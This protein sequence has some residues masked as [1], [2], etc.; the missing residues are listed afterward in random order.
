MRS[1]F[2]AKFFFCLS[3]L[4]VV[5]WFASCGQQAQVPFFSPSS[6]AE[7][8]SVLLPLSGDARK[9]RIQGGGSALFAFPAAENGGTALASGALE[10]SLEI[11]GAGSGESA[12][13]P[14]DIRLA[15]LT[16]EDFL[17]AGKNGKQKLPYGLEE[18]GLIFYE[19]T[20]LM[21]QTFPV[22]PDYPKT[23]ITSL[24]SFISSTE[25]KLLLNC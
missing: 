25:E 15:F 10:V 19:Y 3:G 17:P 14:A 24:K 2:T 20:F 1:R 21:S 9:G 4:G 8:F 16:Q 7:S 6:G 11:R 23:K 22:I 18:K 12:C 13:P 5:L